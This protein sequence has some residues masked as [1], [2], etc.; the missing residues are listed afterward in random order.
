MIGMAGL[1]HIMACAWFGLGEEAMGGDNWIVHFDLLDKSF[2]YQYTYSLHWA[3]ATITSGNVVGYATNVG[4]FAFTIVVLTFAFALCAAAI[5]SITSSMTRLDIMAGRE[6]E[7]FAVLRRYLN[8]HEISPK[9]FSRVMRN[10]QETLMEKHR[11]IAEQDVELLDLVSE[12][13]RV[14]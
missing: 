10:S 2:A 1:S 13:L 5:S 4:E 8:D 11:N 7:Q 9:L 12:P 14:E 6:V 3:L